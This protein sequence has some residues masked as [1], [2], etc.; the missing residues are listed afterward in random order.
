M[1][2][3]FS[4]IFLILAMLCLLSQGVAGRAAITEFQRL[5]ET[6]ASGSGYLPVYMAFGFIQLS[7]LAQALF[8]GL[9]L[10]LS[11]SKMLRWIAGTGLAAGLLVFGAVSIIL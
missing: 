5:G 7:G 10:W 6:N 1:K 9:S 2:K 11:D 4:I 3:T 8:C